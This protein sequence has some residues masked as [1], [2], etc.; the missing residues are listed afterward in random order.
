MCAYCSPRVSRSLCDARPV[1]LYPAYLSQLGNLS[2]RCGILQGYLLK[3]VGYPQSG[4]A[5]LRGLRFAELAEECLRVLIYAILP[6]YFYR[7]SVQDELTLA[8]PEPRNELE[9]R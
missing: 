8:V 2:I 3:E 5:G 9:V 6:F 7:I 1:L 4:L